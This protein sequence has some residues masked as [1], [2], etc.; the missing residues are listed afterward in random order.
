MPQHLISVDEVVATLQVIG[1]SKETIANFTKQITF[2]L[3]R[4][5]ALGDEHVIVTTLHGAASGQP[6]VNLQV[7]ATRLQMDVKSAHKVGFDILQATEAAISDA[8]VMRL[9][10][11]KIGLDVARA[12]RVMIDLREMRQGSRDAVFKQ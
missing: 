8:A 6:G 11:E 5:P 10:V 9:L 2:V 3:E 7:G 1:A 4:R 12:S